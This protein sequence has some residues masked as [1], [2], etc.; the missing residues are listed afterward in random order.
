[1][2]RTSAL[3]LV[4]LALRLRGRAD[5]VARAD[6]DRCRVAYD[7][8]DGGAHQLVGHS[9]PRL[10]AAVLDRPSPDARPARG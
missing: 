5:G 4:A 3:A 7:G 9:N 2:C 6:G 1:M 10:P 8:R